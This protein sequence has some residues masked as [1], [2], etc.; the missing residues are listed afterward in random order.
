MIELIELE[1]RAGDATA[2]VI[3][4]PGAAARVASFAP[5]TAERC[6]LIADAAALAL[7]GATVRAMLPPH[8]V[9]ALTPGEEH[10]SPGELAALWSGLANAG[11]HRGDWIVALGGGVTTDLAGLAAAT[12]NRGIAVVHAPSTLLGQVDA[13]IGGK[14]AVD[15][16]EGKNLVGAFHHPRAVVCDTTFLATLPPAVFATG[17]AE[18]IKHALIADPGLLDDMRGLTPDSDQETLAAFVARA[19]SVKI[20]VVG[21][22]P[23]EQGERAHLNYGHTLGHA[24]ESHGAYGALSHGEA[25]S[26]GMM[27]AANLAAR[28]GHADLIDLHRAALED[29]ALPVKGARAPFE[30]IAHLW[31]RDKKYAR[32]MRFVL[33]RDLAQ[34]YVASDVPEDALRAAYGAVR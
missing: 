8:E 26:L 12:Y 18:C 13:A 4:G 28:L 27:F 3:I 25:V 23:Y 19:V 29:A 20:A 2:P 1:V 9:F 6:A 31:T 5:R 33:L 30:E 15:L 14:T 7:H 11:I 32:G 17:K 34:P 24:L 22:D 10:K 21:R 16:P